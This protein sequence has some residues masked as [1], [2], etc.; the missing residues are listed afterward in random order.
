VYHGGDTAIFSDMKLQG[1]LYG[2]HIGL[3]HVTGDFVMDPQY[4]V[5]EMSPYEA[6]LASRWLGLDVAVAC[7][8]T[9]LPNAQVEEYR[10][11]MEQMNRDTGKV[12]QVV[13][14]QPGES[15]EYSAK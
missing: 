2:P 4:C 3:I 5:A 11:I 13:T 15:F 14:M 8:Y 12:V 7:H 6:A 10:Q 9:G 1:E